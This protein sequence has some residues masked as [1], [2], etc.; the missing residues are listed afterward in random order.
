MKILFLSH[1][2]NGLAQRLFVELAALGHEVSIEI[3]VNDA[4][5]A[6][7]V[8]LAAPDLIIAPF[9]KRAIPA[10]IFSRVPC[11][12][13]HPGIP[14]DRG[15]SALDWAILEGEADWGV[16][17]LQAEAEMDAGPVWASRCFR[18]RAAPKSS[19]YR[20]E[21]AEGA[22]QAVLEAVARFARGDAPMSLAELGEDARGRARPLMLQADRAID[23]ENDDTRTVLAKIHAADGFPGVRDTILCREVLLFGAHDGKGDVP[24]FSGKMGNVPDF[25]GA[26]MATRD[27]AILRRTVDEI[28]RA[29]CRERV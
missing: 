6:E 15:P 28:G 18:M 12:V 5:T 16:T 23:W 17:V 9:L 24:Q 20:R 1:A 2:F 14:G 27:G 8:A 7:A 10:S 25:R 4:V 22:A 19:L 21:V 13:V 3:D 11:F 29:S 26:V